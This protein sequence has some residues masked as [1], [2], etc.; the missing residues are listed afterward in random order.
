LLRAAPAG[1]GT[2]VTLQGAW[3]HPSFLGARLPDGH[4]VSDQG[5]GGRAEPEAVHLPVFAFAEHVGFDTAYIGAAGA[6]APLCGLCAATV[7]CSALKGLLS[8]I[9]FAGGYGLIYLLLKSEDY[10]LLIGSVAAFGAVAL[11]MAVT[12]NLDWYGVRRS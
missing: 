1:E 9:A 4:Q 5:V 12:R 7:F 2:A 3:P 6:T 10:A 11:T 8:F